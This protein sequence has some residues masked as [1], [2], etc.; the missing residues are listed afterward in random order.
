MKKAPAQQAPVKKAP[1]Q[2]APVKKAPAGTA[3]ANKAPTKK[4]APRR[5]TSAGGPGDR[6]PVRKPTEKPLVDPGTAK[7]VASE[8]E[9]LQKAADVDKD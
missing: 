4:T 1:A 7:T 5:T 8:A 3:P 9:T 2:Q 6:L